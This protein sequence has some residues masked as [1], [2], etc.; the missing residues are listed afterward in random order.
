MNFD[1]LKNQAEGLLHDHKDQVAEGLDKA[2]GLLK[3]KIGHD[4]EVDK[5]EGFLKDQLGKA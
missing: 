2:A 5:A 3:G 1:E 4:N